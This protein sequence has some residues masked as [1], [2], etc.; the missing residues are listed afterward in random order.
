M[1]RHTR[2]QGLIVQ[3]EHVLLIRVKQLSTDHDFWVIPGG[4]IENYETEEECIIREIQE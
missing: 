1:I 2:Y 4:G 3:D